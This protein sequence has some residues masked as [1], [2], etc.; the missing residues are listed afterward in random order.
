MYKRQ[1]ATDITFAG[2]AIKLNDGSNLVIDTGST[3]GNITIA[4]IAGTSLETVTLD[5]GSGTT[6]VGVIGNSTEIGTLS[7]GS[8]QNGGITLNGAIVVDDTATFDG[9]VSLATGAISVTT[10]NDDITFNHSINGTQTLTLSSGSGAIVIDG[11]IGD[12]GILTALSINATDGA[13]GT[14]EVANIGATAEGV[15]TG[16]IS[17]GNNATNSLTLDGTIYRTDGT[18]IYEAK[19]GGTILLTGASPH[20][21]TK[22]DNLTFDLGDLVLSTNGTTT[23]DTNLG[24][25]L[26]YTSDAADD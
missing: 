14:I 7:I 19:A 5:A 8:A 15:N 4:E 9:P 24:S 20:I 10:T 2:G 25:C 13:S 12:T 17:I 16:A 3:G 11:A 22:G 6:S 23:I 26:L 1:G 18:T 21:Q